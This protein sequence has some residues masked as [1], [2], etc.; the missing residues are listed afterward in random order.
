MLDWSNTDM[1]EKMGVVTMFVIATL[2]IILHI[3]YI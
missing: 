2:C 1:A 3:Y